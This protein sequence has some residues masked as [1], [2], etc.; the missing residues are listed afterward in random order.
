M[1]V[2]KPSHVR[3]VR[4]HLAF[5]SQS[6]DPAWAGW[7]FF[8]FFLRDRAHSVLNVATFHYDHTYAKRSS[9]TGWASTFRSVFYALRSDT[10]LPPLDILGG[11]FNQAASAVRPFFI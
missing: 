9:Q 7:G 8:S 5:D 10:S 3:G 1:A 11:D 4:P 6:R 2:A